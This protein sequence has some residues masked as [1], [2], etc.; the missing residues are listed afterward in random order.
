MSKLKELQTRNAKP[1]NKDYRLS[2]GFGLFFMVRT[3]GVRSWQYRYQSNITKKEKIYTL[4]QY[5]EVSLSQARAEHS[6]LRANVLKG[7]DVQAEKI[8]IRN[9]LP[10][11]KDSFKDIAIQW[12]DNRKSRVGQD[13]WNKDWSRV[14]RFIFPSFANKT[15]DEV[16]AKDLLN[17][18]KIV[19][20]TNGRETAMRTMNHVAS[21]LKYAMALGKVKYN[22]ASGL[23]EYL[24]KPQTIIRKALLD[25][26]MLGQYI[27]T[28]ENNEWS[29][30]LVG[31]AIRL[32]PHIF[33][34]HSEMLGMKWSEID[35]NKK[36]WIYKV[37]K[38]QNTG[39]KEHTVFLSEQAIK[40][41]EDIK[42]LTG[43]REAV[44][45]GTGKSKQLSQR[46]T[47]NRIREFGFDIDV[48]GFR[49]TA[50]TLGE[51]KL[52]IH[53]TVL[54]LCLAHKTKESHSDSYDRK[55][56]LPEREQFY[57][58]WSDFLNDCKKKYQKTQIK[59]VS[60]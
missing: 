54:E 45:Y 19:A 11:H 47:M 53:G 15:L 52:N 3:T 44:F 55:T 57:Q 20:E 49:A 40:I 32:I 26:T 60:G 29:K 28:V 56:M 22:V 42:R 51:E 30:D 2:D 10:T 37:G 59:K 46:A 31:C 9:T 18:L 8:K 1:E 13:T 34:R 14:E 21:I 33:V 36:T 58:T 41:L 7:I 39:V 27:Y 35:W 17:K 12:N 25:E 5:P 48:H 43:S 6:L 23:T 24:P 16:Q 38:T 50:R 4:G